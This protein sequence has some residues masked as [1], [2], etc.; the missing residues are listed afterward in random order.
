MAP[1]GTLY[2]YPGN[3]RA[4]KALI[5]AAYSGANVTVDPNFEFGRTNTSEEFL[6]KFPLGKVPAF[7]G[8]DGVCLSQSNAIAHY[9]S[10]DS[11]RGNN[12]VDQALVWQYVEFAE[13]EILPS[14]CTWVYPT[15]GFKQYNKQETE[16]AQNHIKKCLALLNGLL[17]T[18]TF[19]VGERVSLADIVLCCNM[20]MLYAQVLD[21]KFREP[22]GNVNRWFTTCVNQPNFVK[23]LGEFKLCEKMAMFDNKRY[24]ELHPKQQKEKKEAK[25]KQE[26]KPKEEKPKEAKEETPP[27]PK[28]A[29]K[30][31]FANVPESKFVLDTWKKTYSNNDASV[32]QPYLWENFDPN[33][34]SFWFC[35][36]KYPEECTIDWKTLNLVGGMFQR[37]EGIRKHSFG[38]MLLLEKD[39]L[40]P[41]S[42]VWLQKG[43]DL[44][45]ELNDDWNTDAEHF[46]FQKLDPLNKA[47]D[48]D[49]I[50]SYNNWEGP[51]LEGI[52]VNDGMT[53]K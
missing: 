48:K 8:S 42:G 25:P 26:K 30:D 27:P 6:K 23:V 10:N 33:A 38:T 19:L 53:W 21:A 11:L 9:L 7:E 34:W 18:R 28:P 5:A 32:F 44:I 52:T 43:Q 49:L 45:F 2:T 15:L 14:A 36:Y 20:M 3:Y 29:K 35:E 31:Y 22:Y 50:D 4:Q 16:K 13:N 39:G 46:N 37:I 1:T 47:T 24:Q 40:F 17:E 12:P 51:A 41:I